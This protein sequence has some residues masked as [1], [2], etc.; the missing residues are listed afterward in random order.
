MKYKTE[1]IKN[2]HNKDVTFWFTCPRCHQDT[3]LY[4]HDG[5]WIKPDYCGHCGVR[6]SM[7]TTFDFRI[8]YTEDENR[9]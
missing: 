2:V 9:Q 3:P 5:L 4:V 6:L 8:D 1:I 7:Y